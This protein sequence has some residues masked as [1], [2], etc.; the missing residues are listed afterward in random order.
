MA[1]SP[2]VLLLSLVRIARWVS[3]VARSPA[4][5]RASCLS[6]VTVAC[7]LSLFSFPG[8][9]GSGCLGQ[10][11]VLEV[12]LDVAVGQGQSSRAGVQGRSE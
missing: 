10:G 12:G 2:V 7:R 4:S 8:D 3:L 9:P 1:Q 11:S 6:R 5:S